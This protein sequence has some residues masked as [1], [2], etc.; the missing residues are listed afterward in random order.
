M[1]FAPHTKLETEPA[2]E[3]V[4]SKKKTLEKLRVV[5][6]GPAYIKHGRRVVYQVSDLDAWIDQHR[7]TSTSANVSMEAR[8]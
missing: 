4:G 8:A 2:A 3:Y 1:S 6:G 7:R 5:G